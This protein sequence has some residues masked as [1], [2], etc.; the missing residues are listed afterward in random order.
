MAAWVPRD[1]SRCHRAPRSESATS[2]N[3]SPPAIAATTARA[4]LIAS[5]ARIVAAA[6]DA[7]RRLERDLHD[8]AQQRLV[9]LGLLLRSAENSLPPELHD[10]KTAALGYRFRVKR[11]VGRSPRNFA[12]NPS[13][14]PFQR[15]APP[16]TEDTGPPLAPCPSSLT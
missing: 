3:C 1:R 14:D 5:R 10:Q 7:R 4:D 11:C 13:R 16:C 8:G 2:P 12:R 6:D 9:S 15:W